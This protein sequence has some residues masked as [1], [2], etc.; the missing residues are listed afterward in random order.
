[1]GC[2]VRIMKVRGVSHSFVYEMRWSCDRNERKNER[3]TGDRSEGVWRG[4]NT[5]YSFQFIFIFGFGPKTHFGH[6]TVCRHGDVKSFA[7]IRCGAMRV[8]DPCEQ[9]LPLIDIN[10]V[11]NVLR[12]S[13]AAWSKGKSKLTTR[14]KKT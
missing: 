5:Q 1:M 9:K 2:D 12:V 14:E 13:N 11:N 8:D 10:D 3:K 6:C 7:D 4:K